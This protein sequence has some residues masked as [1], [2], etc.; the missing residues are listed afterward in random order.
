MNF[1]HA[2]KRQL[3]QIALYESC[4][5]KDKYAAIRELELRKN[6]KNSGKLKVSN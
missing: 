4:P 2:T 3:L 1:E 6:L 5:I